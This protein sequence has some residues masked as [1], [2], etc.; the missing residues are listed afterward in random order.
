[1][2]TIQRRHFGTGI[3]VGLGLLTAGSVASGAMVLP[4]GTSYQAPAGGTLVVDELYGSN[5][6]GQGSWT[7]KDDPNIT[8]NPESITVV[9]DQDNKDNSDV[10]R[11]LVTLPF[12]IYTTAYVIDI[13]LEFW[14]TEDTKPIFSMLW[15]PAS[16]SGCKYNYI[17]EPKGDLPEDTEATLRGKTMGGPIDFDQDVAQTV[18]LTA[19]AGNAANPQ[20]FAVIGTNSTTTTALKEG[21]AGVNGIFMTTAPDGLGEVGPTTVEVSWMKVYTGVIDNSPPLTDAPVLAGDLDSDGFVG[22]ADLN[23][24]LG[25]WNLNIPPANPLADPSGDG[26]I[27]IEDLNMVL[28]NWNAGT[29]P[30]TVAIPE[31][32]SLALLGLG[33][34]AM[35][36]RRTVNS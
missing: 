6:D 18:R 9:L 20:N 27:G 25:S 26:F 28:G 3:V 4:E 19:T 35:L 12:D 33:G 13:G 32:A 16:T 30:P 29:P 22:I 24:V 31:P 21:A 36:R 15:I 34:L 11:T 5:N 10:F 17:T 2:Q 8:V 1:M 14:T 7:S 23:I